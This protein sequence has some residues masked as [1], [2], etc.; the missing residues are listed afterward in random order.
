MARIQLPPD[1][2]EVSC[3]AGQTLLEALEDG[4]VAWPNDCR[5]GHCGTCKARVR[6]GEVDRGLYLPMALSDDE[7]DDGYCLPCVTTPRSA[8]V[9]L[10]RRMEGLIPP[11]RDVPFVVTD[12]RARTPDIVELR[13]RPTGAALRYRAGQYVELRAEGGSRPYSIANAPRSDGELSLHVSRVPG[14]VV[15]GWVHSRLR[16]GDV[17]RVSGPYGTFVGDPAIRGPVL[18]LAGGSGLAPI[19]ALTDAALRRGYPD[20]VRLVL[21][22][23]TPEGVNTDGLIGSWRRRYGTFSFERTITR[24]AGDRIPPPVGRIDR[25]LPALVGDLREHAVFIAGSPGFVDT[26]R[27]AVAGLG[28]DP[29]RVHVEKY[30]PQ[31]KPYV[32]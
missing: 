13:L 15:S 29:G 3:G 11:R 23:R 9:V 24:P 21:S 25:V 4:G 5:A 10:D 22:A 30:F 17:V 19:L 2:P 8:T 1:G 18:C 27:G 28:V 20:P 16:A 6:S 31:G 12:K 26:A 14:G 32:R 7:V